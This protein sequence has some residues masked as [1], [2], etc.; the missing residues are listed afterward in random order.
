VS[1]TFAHCQHEA[2]HTV[3]AWWLVPGLRVE[4]VAVGVHATDEGV[5]NSSRV[6]GE[7]GIGDLVVSLVGWIQ[8]PDLPEGAVW[9]ERWPVR[10]DAPEGVGRIVRQLGLSERQYQGACELAEELVEEPAFR[11]AV[12]LVARALQI[13]PALDYEALEVLREAAGIPNN[14]PEPIPELEGASL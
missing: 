6:S 13:A 11:E 12:D 1:T 14:I 4:S 10:P 8:D 3:G 5:M 9:P 7:L 2:R